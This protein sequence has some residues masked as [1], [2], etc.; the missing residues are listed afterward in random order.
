MV[1]PVVLKADIVSKKASEKEGIQ[2]LQYA[3]SMPKIENTNH[4]SATTRNPSLLC[5]LRSI[6]GVEKIPTRPKRQVVR[7]AGKY[8]DSIKNVDPM[9]LL[10]A[11]T[12]PEIE[13]ARIVKRKDFELDILSEEQA[14]DQL[15]LIGN[16]FYIYRDNQTNLVNVVY[17]REDGNYGLIETR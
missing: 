8:K 12:V 3:G 7:V 15:E 13:P 2:P 14:I 1:A 11:E 4:T 17:K 9:D 5:K 16:D 6:F 10:F